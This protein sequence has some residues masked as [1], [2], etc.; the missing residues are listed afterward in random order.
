MKY[1]VTLAGDTERIFLFP[2]EYA[3]DMFAEALSCMRNGDSRWNWSREYHEPVSAGFTDG[4]T[5]WGYSETLKLGARPIVDAALLNHDVKPQLIKLVPCP[6]CGSEAV[7]PT[8]DVDLLA[9]VVIATISCQDKNCNVHMHKGV[10]ID[11]FVTD[12]VK[13]AKLAVVESW[14]GRRSLPPNE[15]NQSEV[16]DAVNDAI[17][18]SVLRIALRS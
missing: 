8:V 6:F 12:S 14:N 1:V 2:E 15:T 4:V 5:C 7:G 16:S 10:T 9:N 3:H 18:Q 13:E 17:E 11:R